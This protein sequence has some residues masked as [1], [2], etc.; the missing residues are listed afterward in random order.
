MRIKNQLG[1]CDIANHSNSHG[2]TYHNLRS[3]RASGWTTCRNAKAQAVMA[4]VVPSPAH[5]Y[6]Q[7]VVSCALLPK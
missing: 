6:W 7:G 3:F 5:L 2:F 4:V 1:S